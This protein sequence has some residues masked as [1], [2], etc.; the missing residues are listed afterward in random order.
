MY[1]TPF[2]ILR[3]SKTVDSLQEVDRGS[4]PKAVITTFQREEEK[5]ISEEKNPDYGYW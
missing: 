1:Q 2:Y 3:F 4:I 5:I